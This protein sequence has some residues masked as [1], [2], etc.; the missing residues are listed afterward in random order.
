MPIALRVHVKSAT[1]ASQ[2]LEQER[3]GFRGGNDNEYGRFQVLIH[4]VDER[5]RPQIYI[6]HA[7]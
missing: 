6:F 7:L 1:C 2:V 4:G 3:Y 5:T